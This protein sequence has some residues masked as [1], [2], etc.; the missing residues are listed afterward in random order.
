MLLDPRQLVMNRNVIR[1]QRRLCAE[2]E[3]AASS[4]ETPWNYFLWTVKVVKA[5]TLVPDMEDAS[6]F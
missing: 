6:F 1:V 4:E 5:L 3:T 2:V